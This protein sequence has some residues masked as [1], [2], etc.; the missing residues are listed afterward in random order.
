MSYFGGGYIIPFT[1][2]GLFVW[3]F[4]LILAIVAITILTKYQEKIESRVLQ[5]ISKISKN[6]EKESA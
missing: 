3:P 5:L 4:I 2:W 6:K 1:G